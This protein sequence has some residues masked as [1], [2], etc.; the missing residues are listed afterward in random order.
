MNIAADIHADGQAGKR[1]WV[2]VS[3]RR[4]TRSQTIALGA[5]PIAVA[6]GLM[7]TG[8]GG[9]P[10]DAAPPPATVTAA[11]P[12]VRQVTEWDDYSGRFE[13]SR[14]VEVRPRVS[15]AIVGVHFTDGSVVRPG[16]LLFTIDSRPFAAALSEARAA[17]QG[18]QSELAL[19]RADLGRAVRLLEVEAVSRSDVDRLRARVQ[20]AEA[21]LAAAQARVRSRALD[22]GFTQ[23]R[24]PIGGRISDR[25]VDAG[26]LVQGGAAGGEATLLTTI[27]ALD[28]MY[29]TF[30]ASEALFLKARRAQEDGSGG[31]AVQIRLQ[32]ETDYR[33]SGRL[34]FTDNGLDTR[35]GTIR[36]R[37]VVSN[38]TRFLTPG[39]FGNMRLASGTSGPALLVP[40][41]A[42]QTDQARKVVLVVSKDGSLTPRPVEVG[43]VLDGLRVIRSGLGTTDR[44]V[45]SGGQ[46]ALPGAKVNVRPGVI[47]PVANQAAAPASRP[48]T[49]AATFAAR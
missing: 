15:G 22:V 6:A 7:L 36:L 34:D 26:N 4:L 19:A 10:V 8:T 2:R 27:N 13:A 24:A 20:A 31:T 28:P 21:S 9:A 49:G 5:L 48:L 41:A 14:T 25:R 17:V 44:V 46:L 1:S 43:P 16:Q 23:V 37:A 29:F 39:M 12:L 3:K 32:D 35:S 11:A 30:D 38:A 18:A 42:V 45:I 33:W 40:D 47:R